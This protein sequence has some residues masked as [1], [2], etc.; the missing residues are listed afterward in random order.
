M[1][2]DAV[3]T[4]TTELTANELGRLL[5]EYGWEIID[6]RQHDWH[7]PPLHIIGEY[8]RHPAAFVIE[9]TLVKAADNHVPILIQ[10]FNDAEPPTMWLRGPVLRW[11]RPERIG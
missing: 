8:K 3:Q 6:E 9:M 1:C 2:H 10:N 11:D 7:I 4:G 5:I